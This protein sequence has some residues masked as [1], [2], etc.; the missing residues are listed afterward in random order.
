MNPYLRRIAVFVEIFAVFFGGTFAARFLLKALAI[1]GSKQAIQAGSESNWDAAA[2]AIPML[3]RWSIVIAIAFLVGWLVARHRPRDYGLTLAGRSIGWHV[4]AAL[5][6]LAIGFFPVLLLL[7]ARHYF[8]LPGGPAIWN[9]LDRAPRTFDFWMFMLASSIVIPPLVEETFFRGY[10]QTRLCTAFRPL[11]AIISAALLFALAH[12]QYLDGSFVGTAAL[13][14]GIW[15]FVIL[16]LMR[17]R[18]GSLLAGI[19][20]H[21]LFNIPMRMTEQIVFAIALLSIIA[22]VAI[23]RVDISGATKNPLPAAAERGFDETA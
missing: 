10:V 9:A 18:T 12:V 7:L 5:V 19:I 11:T 15:Q 16:G 17:L 2:V 4:K 21:A 20:A 6:G 14:L 3:I 8:H 1:T 13:L 23:R 22:F